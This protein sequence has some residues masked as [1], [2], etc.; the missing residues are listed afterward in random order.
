MVFASSAAVYGNLQKIPVGEEDVLSPISPYG[1]AKLASEYLVR[2]YATS[3]GLTVRIQR[4]FNVYGRRQ[5]PSSP[6]SGVISVFVRNLSRGRPI[7]IYGDGHQTRDFINVA[8]VAETNFL[9]ATL[10][11]VLSGT[12]NICTG[13]P[14]SLREIADVLARHSPLS[15]LELCSREGGGYS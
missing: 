9:A 14:V 4:Y 15:A 12:A 10:P 7:T 1:S 3:Y 2:S 6:Y 5:D 13:Q 11:G 8:D